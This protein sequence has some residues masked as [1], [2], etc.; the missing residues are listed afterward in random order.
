MTHLLIDGTN[1]AHRAYHAAPTAPESMFKTWVERV[2][3]LHALC[4][5]RKTPTRWIAFDAPAC[6]RKALDPSYKAKRGDRDPAITAWLARAQTLYQESLCV[7]GYE[8]DDLL[9][10]LCKGRSAWV[11]TGDR[12]AYALVS[13]RVVVIRPPQWERLIDCDAVYR[14]MGVWPDQVPAFKALAGDASDNIAGAPGIGPVKARRLLESYGTL[15][16]VL[17]CDQLTE[18]QK[19]GALRARDLVALRDNVPVW[20]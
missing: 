2:T 4:H 5:D 12:D 17:A 11:V 14:E 1:L 19:E 15:D 7:P 3:S 10:T 16:G 9:A 6:F 20:P 18:A 8:A 13:H